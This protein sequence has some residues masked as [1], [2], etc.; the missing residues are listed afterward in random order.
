MSEV[1]REL[2]TAFRQADQDRGCSLPELPTSTLSTLM[3]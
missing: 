3:E 1:S 2:L